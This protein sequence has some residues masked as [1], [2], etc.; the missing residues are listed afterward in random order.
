MLNFNGKLILESELKIDFQNRAFK[1]GDAVFD[2]LKYHQKIYFIEEHYFRLMSSMRMLRMKIPMNFTLQFYKDEIIKT[3]NE[4]NVAGS[5]RIRVNIFRK[6]GGLYT[7]ITNEI[8]YLIETDEWNKII[9]KSYEI[10]LFKDFSVPSGLLSTIKTNNRIVNVLSSIFAAEN[11]YDNC[12]LLNEKKNIVEAN[13]ANIFLIFGNKIVTP[14]LKEGCINGI[15]RMKII[16][17][18]KDSKEFILNEKSI[19]PFELLK[20]NEIFLTNSIFEIQPVTKY[21]KKLFSTIMTQKIKA[22]FESKKEL[23]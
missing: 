16:E 5:I 8:N 10:E 3:I 21:R 4:N 12:I 7:P 1:Y 9:K 19:S 14:P 11:N 15:V 23:V 6:K 18:F 20:A 17:F 22:I 13:N 2:T